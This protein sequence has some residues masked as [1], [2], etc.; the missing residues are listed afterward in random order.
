MGYVYVALEDTDARPEPLSAAAGQPYPLIRAG[1]FRSETLDTN[2]VDAIQKVDAL[3]RLLQSLLDETTIASLKRA[4]GGLDEI[5]AALA[6]NRAQLTSL[7]RN[8]ERDTRDLGV[9]LGASG[10][11]VRQLQTELLPQVARTAA[12]LDTAVRTLNSTAKPLLDA[13]NAT[14]REVRSELLPQFYKAAADLD[15]MAH[16]L[17]G[18]L[19]RLTRDPSALV[20][21]TATPP[22]PGERP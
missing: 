17:N 14:L 18:I 15:G 5:T 10:N 19:N 20:R 9:L 22:G 11:L 1:P 21:G 6:T 8:A 12:D 4:I 16:T 13:S 2:V 7:L 3:L